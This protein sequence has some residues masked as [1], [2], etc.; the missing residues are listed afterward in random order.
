ST[1]PAVCHDTFKV[2]HG[3]VLDRTATG[4]LAIG[5]GRGCKLLPKF[6]HGVKEY[7]VKGQLGISTTTYNET[8]EV[9]KEL[10]YGHVTK[11]HLLKAL[12]KFRGEIA[13]TPPVYSALKLNGR[14]YSDL[15]SDG[16]EVNPK[17]RLVQCHSLICT[18]FDPPM[19]TLLVKCGGGFYI[20]SLIH[21]LGI[22]VGS[23]AHVKELH[24][25]QHGVFKEYQAIS[26]EQ[27]TLQCIIQHIQ[28]AK[29]SYRNIFKD[30]RPK[31]LKSERRYTKEGS[32]NEKSIVFTE[33]MFDL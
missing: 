6:L 7:I 2:G 9:M 25:T 23:C 30:S 3:G 33:D 28:K 8:G 32:K 21:D 11:V 1:I 18:S 12:T 14:R 20:R 29:K 27:W 19:F 4:V 15:A 13:Q 5:V 22:E 26:R 16:V 10:P 24:R 31:R 17:P